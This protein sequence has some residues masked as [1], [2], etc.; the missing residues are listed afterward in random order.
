ML[1]LRQMC[2]GL[3]QPGLNSQRTEVLPTRAFGDR[4]GKKNPRMGEEFI[5]WA[6]EDSIIRIILNAYNYVEEYI[7]PTAPGRKKYIGYIADRTGF[8]EFKRWALKDVVLP[9]KAEGI[10]PVY[11]NGIKY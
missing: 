3:S 1:R 8:E 5:K 9:E 7:D 4:T 6:D 11:C 10:T 2:L